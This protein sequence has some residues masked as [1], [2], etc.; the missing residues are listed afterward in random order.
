MIK[1][2]LCL[3]FTL[4]LAAG[5]GESKS[6]AG[7]HA[8][9]EGFSTALAAKSARDHADF[10]RAVTTYRFWHPT[11]SCRGIVPGSVQFGRV[12]QPI[13]HQIG[14]LWARRTGA[15]GMGI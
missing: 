7:D 3:A 10:Q 1:T 11:V 15:R 2:T 6:S 5:A 4:A 13:D 8:F 12:V 9:K 14:T